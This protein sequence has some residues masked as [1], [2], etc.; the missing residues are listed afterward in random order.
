MAIGSAGAGSGSGSSTPVLPEEI[1]VAEIASRPE[2]GA[3][4]LVLQG[5]PWSW[6]DLSNP[7][8]VAR[9]SGVFYVVALVCTG[10][11]TD[12]PSFCITVII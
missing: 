12:F 2:S 9:G 4:P 11:K 5:V 8:E 10:R 6:A 3:V 7:E 1:M